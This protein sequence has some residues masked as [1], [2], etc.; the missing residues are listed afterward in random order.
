MTIREDRHGNAV[1]A[2]RPF[3]SQAVAVGPASVL[4]APFAVNQDR[5]VRADDGSTQPVTNNHTRHIRVVSTVAC[6]ISFGTNPVAALRST[7]SMYMPA[8]LPEYFWVTVGEQL[9]VIQDSAA[10]FLYV[11]EL[12]N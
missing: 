4:L 11:S 12:T 1:Q 3:S 5:P 6:W 8:G 7:S 2:S 10:G 9:A